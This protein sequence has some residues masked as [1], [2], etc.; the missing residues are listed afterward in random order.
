MMNS[1]LLEGVGTVGT[2]L[3]S[4]ELQELLPV[5]YY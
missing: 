3:S 5:P 1:R 2:G 4:Q